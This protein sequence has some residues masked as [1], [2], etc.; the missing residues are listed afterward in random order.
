MLEV[1]FEVTSTGDTHLKQTVPIFQYNEVVGAIVSLSDGMFLSQMAEGAGYGIDGYGYIIDSNGPIIGHPNEE[2]VHNGF[3]PI[4][5]AQNDRSIKSTANFFETILKEKQG[6]K[7][8]HKGK[9]II[10]WVCPY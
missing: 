2:F 1:D 9:G 5:E 10:C 4:A 8:I 7:K 6:V 3:N